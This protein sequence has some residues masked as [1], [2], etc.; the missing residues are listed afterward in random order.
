MSNIWFSSNDINHYFPNLRTVH[1]TV[2]HMCD[3]TLGINSKWRS[4]IGIVPE[5]AVLCAR[6]ICSVTKGGLGQTAAPQEELSS[7]GEHAGERAA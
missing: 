7:A 3:S 2:S 1:I 4:D 6:H 5:K